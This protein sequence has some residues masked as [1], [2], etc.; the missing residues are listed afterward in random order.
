MAN[1][2]ENK[3]IMFNLPSVTLV[4][5]GARSG[6]SF[7]AES[8]IEQQIATNWDGATFIATATSEDLEM[9]KRILEHR[10]RRGPNWHT[11]EEP[12]ELTMALK[13]HSNSNCPVLVDCLT[14]WLTNLMLGNYD[15]TLRT[16]EFLNQLKMV[17]GPVV[18]VS[19]ETGLSIV[20]DNALAREFR[21]HAGSLNRQVALCA[22]YVV[23]IVAGLPITLKTP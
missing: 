12:L 16:R 2:P 7:W 21:D 18:L 23:L 22:D 10:A 15:V 5:G 1:S 17:K 14:L 4:L 9:N 20:P 11:V 6:K 19:N 3:N 8:L 13:N